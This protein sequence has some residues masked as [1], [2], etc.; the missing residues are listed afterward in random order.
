MRTDRQTGMTKL[1]VAL[2]NF[3]IA[4]NTEKICNDLHV[5]FIVVPCNSI[6][7]KFLFFNQQMHLLLKI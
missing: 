4:P 2:H 6:T 1:R 5:F 7:L 3:P